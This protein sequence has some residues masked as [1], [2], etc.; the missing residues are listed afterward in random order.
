MAIATPTESYSSEWRRALDGLRA[1]ALDCLQANLAVVADLHHGEGAHLALGAPLRF[2]AADGPWA[3][4]VVAPSLDQRLAEAGELLGLRVVQR[5]DDLDGRRLREL[6]QQ[7]ELLYVVADAY[8][9]DW[10]PYAGRLHI[11][12]SFLLIGSER[13]CLVID[14]YSNA[15]QWGNARPGVWQ[16]EASELDA[17]V[18]AACAIALAA[19]RLPMLD[20]AAVLHANARGLAAAVPAIDD[21]VAAVRRWRADPDAIARLVL[22]VWV[23]GRARGLHA[24]WL[25]TADQSS[26]A[27]SAAAARQAQAWL[28]LTAQS[29]VAMRRSQ[30]GGSLPDAVIDELARLLHEDVALAQRLVA[31]EAVGEVEPGAVDAP[32]I[33]AAVVEAIG[34]VLHIVNGDLTARR[35]LRELPGFDSFALVEIIERIEASLRVTVDPDTL[36]A[37][38]LRS[39]DSLCD[40][41]A[42]A[43]APGRVIRP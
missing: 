23:L 21:Y 29:Y 32:A 38:S 20:R 11:E 18:P 5:W 3:T 19:D 31:A 28:A 14:A 35:S 43:N 16:L 26:G 9:L 39:V 33:R 27:G 25:A 17:C 6:A 10:V 34:D 12:H 41:F 7:H 24:A 42:R 30:R 2:L 36:T 1:D 37:E 8:S 40:L 22:D 15:T 4:A 13:S